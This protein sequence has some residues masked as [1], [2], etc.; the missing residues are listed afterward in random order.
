MGIS[1][2]M[3]KERVKKERPTKETQ[4]EECTP[5][6]LGELIEGDQWFEVSNECDDDNEQDQIAVMT[7]MV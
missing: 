4:D 3:P 7:G 2:L 6:K 1:K 5:D